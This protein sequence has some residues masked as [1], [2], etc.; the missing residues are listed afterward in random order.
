MSRETRKPPVPGPASQMADKAMAEAKAQLDFLE[1]F[2][3]ERISEAS[4]ALKGIEKSLKKVD[5]AHTRHAKDEAARRAALAS[6]ETGEDDVALARAQQAMRRW[7][8]RLA[9]ILR[10]FET[11][12][13]TREQVEAYKDELV[14]LRGASC[15]QAITT[16]LAMTAE[17]MEGERLVERS[18]RERLTELGKSQ[19]PRGWPGALR[20]GQRGV[21]DV[22]ASGAGKLGPELPETVRRLVKS[23]HLDAGAAKALV[24]WRD[25]LA[26]GTARA[27]LVQD[28]EVRVQ[29]GGKSTGDVAAS[30]SEAFQ[31]WREACARL[32]P[33]QLEVVNFVMIDEGALDSAP[34]LSRL[35]RDEKQRRAAAGVELVSAAETLRV[36][37]GI[38]KEAT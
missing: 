35:Y 37:Y 10:D 11:L 18:E 16:G 12:E 2:Y 7:E 4:L 19:A 3:S 25:D 8:K 34:G 29:G 14:R 15:N 20:V 31:R 28:Y 6:A 21:I 1:A 33:S 13:T 23:G 26:W 30:K 24:R 32:L 27:K 17:Q 38:R 5:K 36:F 22:T 9:E